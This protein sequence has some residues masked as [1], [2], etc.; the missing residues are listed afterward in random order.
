MAG[1]SVG[2]MAMICV[3]SV[4]NGFEQVISDSFSAFDPELRITPS[5]SSRFSANDSSILNARAAMPDAIWSYELELDGLIASNEGQS[6]VKILGADQYF[7]AVTG[8]DTLMWSGTFDPAHTGQTGLQAA[9]GIGLAT[10]MHCNADMYSSISL[11]APKSRQVNMARPDANFTKTTFVCNGLFC[12]QQAKYDDNYIIMPIDAVREAYR[13]SDDCTTAINL[14]L[15]H[16]RAAGTQDIRN[17]KKQLSNILGDRFTVADRY[18][19][20]SDFYRISRIEKWTTFMILCFIILVA[21]FNIIGSLSMII[22]DKSE[23]IDLMVSLGASH[24]QILRLFTAEGFLISAS[25]G[26][27]G[28]MAGVA[29]VLAQQH[30][31]FLQLGSGG[32]IT[33]VYPVRLMWSDTALTMAAVLIMG[34]AVAAYTTRSNIRNSIHTN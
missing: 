7:S 19:Q 8:I 34:L 13:L 3:L 18:E 6:P 25:G 14:R 29:L 23:D 31:G 27:T 16:N 2:T 9:I 4:M 24:K 22:I 10:R 5:D 32:Y 15:R 12:V 11:Y 21:T 1:V 33:Q 28:V 17:A 20:Q 26:A 30:Y